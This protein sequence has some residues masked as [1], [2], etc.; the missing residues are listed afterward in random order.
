MNGGAAAG[1]SGKSG[2][3]CYSSAREGKLRARGAPAPSLS[4]RAESSTGQGALSYGYVGALVCPVRLTVS[5]SAWSASTVCLS[6]TCPS[7]SPPTSRLFQSGH[8]SRCDEQQAGVTAT[9]PRCAGISLDSAVPQTQKYMPMG[10]LAAGRPP[11]PPWPRPRNDQY[12]DARP[13][14]ARARHW[15][16]MGQVARR[17]AGRWEQGRYIDAQARASSPASPPPILRSPASFG[18]RV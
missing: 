18:R 14:P 3:D 12:R 1:P 6:S 10:T 11:H 8:G 17:D 7:H 2:P 9:R 15:G 4:S 13:S 16:P 5:R